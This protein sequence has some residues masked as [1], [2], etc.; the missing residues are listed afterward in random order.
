MMDLD[1]DM[2]NDTSFNVHVI[3]MASKCKRIAEWIHSEPEIRE[4]DGP[5]EDI[6]AESPGVLLPAMSS[7][8]RKIISG[9]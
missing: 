5:L 9:S 4:N 2:S 3:L 7:Q 6:Y 8:Q 1:I